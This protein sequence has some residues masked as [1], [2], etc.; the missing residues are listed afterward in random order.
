MNDY[1]LLV[2]NSLGLMCI[3]GTDG[4]LSYVSPAAVRALGWT[5]DD[6]VGHNLRE[7][8]AP[9]TAHLF[10]DYLRRVR[11]QGWDS[12]LMLL[13]A[14]DGSERIWEY[15][16]VMVDGP[17]PVQR[18]LGHAIDV[19]ER[20]HAQQALRRARRDL[21]D[22]QS[23]HESLVEGAPGGICI[24]QD[25]V[26]RFATH[27]LAKMH[28]YNDPATLVGA[29]LSDLQ[30]APERTRIADYTAALLRGE[31]IVK[32][33]EVEHVTRDGKALWVE[34]WSSLVSWRQAPAV[35]ITIVDIDERKRLEARVLQMESAEA[36]ARLAGG[37]A[38]ELNGLV[39]VILGES[40]RVYASLD[41]DARRRRMLAIVKSARLSAKL[42]AELLAFS[43]RVMLRL[44]PLSLSEI[45]LDLAPHIQA[46][47]PPTVSLEC[48]ATPPP[49]PVQAD[50]AQ[51]EGAI[52]HL[53]ANA[54]DAM[55]N[56][57]RLEVSVQNVA[58]AG[59]PTKAD[60]EES[61][62]PHVAITVRDTGHGMDPELRAHLFEPFF[63]AKG[64]GV[65]TGLGLPSVYGIVK[66]HGGFVQ[67]DSA[68][69]RGT[70]VHMYFPPA[71]HPPEHAAELTRGDAVP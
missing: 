63:P 68:R 58:R 34:M 12:G 5:A 25:G 60:G 52:L 17:G 33:Q 46:L 15:R 67:V 43:S 61:A 62:G 70:V 47:L 20:V 36:V 29:R 14:K 10:D 9:T 24:H 30:A 57:G 22:S 8:L 23:R 2:E 53:V 51:I 48:S 55:P 71:F 50:R 6:G 19:T 1:R 35:R 39:T 54:R 44:E 27:K 16:N 69:G 13:Q 3:H 45:V 7:Y 49:W 56:G 11:D 28:G 59:A 4:R 66:Q 18:V 26:I 64:G 65:R 41:D 31:E 38:N 21:D 40:E 37:V 42:A 32:V